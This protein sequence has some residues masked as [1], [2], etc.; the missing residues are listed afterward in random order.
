MCIRVQYVPRHL[1]EDPYDASHQVVTLPDTLREQY[2][3]R[4]LRT[5]LGELGIPQARFG[6]RCW[7]GEQIGLLPLIPQ[8]RRSNEVSNLGA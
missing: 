5:V 7:C 6:A 2:A 1:L 4:A 8:Q 3:L